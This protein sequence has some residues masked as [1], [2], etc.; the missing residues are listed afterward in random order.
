MAD[1]LAEG[2]LSAFKLGCGASALKLQETWLL[3]SALS[4]AEQ[5]G[6]LGRSYTGSRLRFVSLSPQ[7]VRQLR[8]VGLPVHLRGGAVLLYH[9]NRAADSLTRKCTTT[10]KALLL[11]VAATSMDSL[12]T[13]SLECFATLYPV[14]LP[15]LSS[16]AGPCQLFRGR[17]F[18]Q[19]LYTGQASFP[20]KPAKLGSPVQ[21]TAL[22]RFPLHMYACA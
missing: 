6:L 15:A 18:R 11:H 5:V 12:R 3:G 21:S 4:G 22:R 17:E 16:S 8:W 20:T 1:W 2:P 7:F 14:S 10:W 19:A 9:L 13:W